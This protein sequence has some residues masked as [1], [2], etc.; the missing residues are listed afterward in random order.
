MV[1]K[2]TE[3]IRI[4][5]RFLEGRTMGSSYII[6]FLV[7]TIPPGYF[8]HQCHPLPVPEHYIPEIWA[9]TISQKRWENAEIALFLMAF[10]CLEVNLQTG[11]SI[12]IL[13]VKEMQKQND[14]RWNHWSRKQ[15]LSKM[16]YF[17]SSLAVG[18]DNAKSTI[19]LE[20]M[21]GC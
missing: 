3:I 7:E 10:W 4:S 6:S 1:K 2:F 16:M 14:D 9:S 12:S 5:R 17:A 21:T 18:Q 20:I 11:D 15:T 13:P 8:H 19:P